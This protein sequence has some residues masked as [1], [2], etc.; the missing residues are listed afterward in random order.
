MVTMDVQDVTHENDNTTYDV[1]FTDGAQWVYE[2]VS[3]FIRK[4]DLGADIHNLQAY[5][6]YWVRVESGA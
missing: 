2:L 3:D 4:D 6:E 5:V 1:G